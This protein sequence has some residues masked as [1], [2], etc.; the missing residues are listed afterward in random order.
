M[1]TDSGVSVL[2]TTTYATCP[3]NLDVL[4]VPG[5]FGTNDALQDQATITFLAEQG[6]HA[7][8]VTSVCSGSILLAAAGLLDGYKAATH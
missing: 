7:R 3:K 2:P 8:Y 4:F 6:Q 5:G 1:L